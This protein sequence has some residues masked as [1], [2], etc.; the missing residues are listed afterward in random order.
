MGRGKKFDAAQKHFDQKR[1]QMKHE[2][3]YYK[4]QNNELTAENSMLKNRITDLEAKIAIFNELNTYSHDEIKAI[5]EKNDLEKSKA[6]RDE[7]LIASLSFL[8]KVNS[9]NNSWY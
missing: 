2:L 1:I 4:K 6:E 8:E 5:I 7:K 9:T 3:D